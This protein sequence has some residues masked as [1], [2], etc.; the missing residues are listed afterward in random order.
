MTWLPR[1]NVVVPIDFSDD[2]F[3]ALETAR[4]MVAEASDLHVIHVLPV[5][6]P[7][8]PGIIWHTIDDDS[9]SQH[10]QDALERELSKRSADGLRV[11]VRFG[12]PGHEVVQYA[13]QAGAE[14][15]VL[16]CKGRSALTRLLIGSV[17]ERIVRLAHCPVLVLKR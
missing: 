13:E 12:D 4:E 3:A 1:Q 17:A 16:S 9:R 7:A 11:V 8:E 10:A 14:L 5:L 15:V 6:E 2:S